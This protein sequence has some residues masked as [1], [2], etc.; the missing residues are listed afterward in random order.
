MRD[1][2]DDT[3]PLR[4]GASRE[5]KVPLGRQ[6]SDAEDRYFGGTMT[7]HID[8]DEYERLVDDSTILAEIEDALID[9]INR[10]A[11]LTVGLKKATGR[12]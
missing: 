8:I 4:F 7:A 2:D 6:L 3:R 9:F 12:E 1:E 5:D 11:T 10:V